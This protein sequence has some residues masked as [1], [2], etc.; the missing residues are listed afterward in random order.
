MGLASLA[1]VRENDLSG[2]LDQ[3]FRRAKLAYHEIIGS[4]PLSLYC[5]EVRNR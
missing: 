5:T 4:V 2:R 1:H 3:I